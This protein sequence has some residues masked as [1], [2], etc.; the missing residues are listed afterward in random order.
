V[1]RKGALTGGYIEPL[2]KLAAQ[3]N[4]NEFRSQFKSIDDDLD[5]LQREVISSCL[6]KSV[7]V[8][9]RLLVALRDRFPG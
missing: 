2:G 3:A 1:N 4:V 7:I 5:R 9:T 6:A 8:F